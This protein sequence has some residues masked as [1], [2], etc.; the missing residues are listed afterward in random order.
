MTQKTVQAII[1]GKVQGVYFRAYTK[2]AA[3]K[4]GL[5]GWVRNLPDGSVETLIS[6][7]ENQVNKMVDWL[8]TGSPHSDV[9][10]V[11]VD[12]VEKKVSYPSFSIRY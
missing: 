6:G 9:T 11:V 4:L 5:T 3:E 1:Q 8:Q 12:D 2:D 10:K 7:D